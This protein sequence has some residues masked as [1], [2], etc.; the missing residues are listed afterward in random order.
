[1][2]NELRRGAALGTERFSRRVCGIGFETDKPAV[3]D[4]GNAAAS[5]DA[6][7]AIAVY[8]LGIGEAAIGFFSCRRTD[9]VVQAYAEREV[10]MKGRR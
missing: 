4:Y 9:P 10:G 6:E 3:F 5:G 8:A 2:I 7:P 1:M